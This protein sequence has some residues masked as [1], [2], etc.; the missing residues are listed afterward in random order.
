MLT[1]AVEEVIGPVAY[2]AIELDQ[3]H[4][5]PKGAACVVFTSKDSYI[6][7]IAAHDV[8]LSFGTSERNVIGILII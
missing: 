8:I 2:C 7:A 1:M 5:Y 6:K 3:Y 4:F